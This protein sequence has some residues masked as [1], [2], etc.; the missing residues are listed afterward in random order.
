MR[1]VRTS[2]VVASGLVLAVR[3]VPGAVAQGGLGHA[4]GA[5]L[6]AEGLG[7][8]PGLGPSEVALL[9]GAVVAVV[10]AVADE[11]PGYAGPAAAALERARGAAG[12][13]GAAPGPVAG[14][15][16]AVAEPV[17]APGVRVGHLAL[18]V[19]GAGQTQGHRRE[20]R[21]AVLVAVGFDWR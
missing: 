2:P 16:G 18:H 14:P 9:V 7:R 10:A 3:A 5:V 4:H 13:L 6:A 1:S 11:E 20:G 17:Q 21:V 19:P 12:P 15:A 8:T